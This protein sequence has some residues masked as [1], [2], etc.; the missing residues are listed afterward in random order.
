MHINLCLDFTAREN[1]DISERIGEVR[2]TDNDRLG[3]IQY[4]T[5]SE[6]F[7]VFPTDGTIL[8]R[9][10]SILLDFESMT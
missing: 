9:S 2:A 6:E 7:A 4:T 10:S 3:E 1:I 8:L 5:R